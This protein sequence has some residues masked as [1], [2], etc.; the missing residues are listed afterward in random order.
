MPMSQE[1]AFAQYVRILGRGPNLSR[2]LTFD[3][4]EAAARMIAA[5]A[6][7]PAQLGAF[8]CLLRVRTETPDEIAGLARG[9][10]G[11]AAGLSGAD[12][13]WPAYAGK[14]RQPPW[15]LLAALTLARHGIRV[16]MHGAEGHTEGRVYAAQAL[17]A[18]GVPACADAGEAARRLEH[19]G[20]AYVTLATLAPR[21][22]A[23]MDLK[24]LLGVRSPLHTAG[25]LLNPA[26]APFTIAA[27]T[28][29]PYQAVHQRAAELLG[30]PRAAVFKGEG[31]EAE[32][33][34]E[35]PCTVL[36]L[37]DG[38]PASE[39]WAPMLDTARPRPEDVDLG[40][41]RAVWRGEHADPA[42]E[43]AVTGTLALALRYSGR[44]AA[45]AE[46]EQLARDM[47]RGR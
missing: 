41:L 5:G 39:E 32:R 7:E 46:A 18:L 38:R 19:D 44:A 37:E 22:Q 28:H 4:A 33:R 2:P 35:K 14:A 20:F 13:D 42:A 15:F 26:G 23:I 40:L 34:P 11:A 6:V 3:E 21:L 9:L 10:R 36:Y 31:G 17:A 27:V 8:L 30:Q 1:H 43:A 29:P 47:W 24:A 12:I 16:F 45:P 25:R